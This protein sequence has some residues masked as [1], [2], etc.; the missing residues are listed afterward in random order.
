MS[1]QTEL[2]VLRARRN[3]S[4]EEAA[5]MLGVSRQVYS[6]VE[7]GSRK[8]T[9]ELWQRIQECYSLTDAEVWRIMT[10]DSKKQ[11]ATP[12]I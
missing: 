4:Q 8:G 10:N 11:A 5:A 3:L 1:R 2:K 12:D 9:P 6:S 7:R